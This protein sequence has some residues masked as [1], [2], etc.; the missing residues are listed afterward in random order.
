MGCRTAPSRCTRRSQPESQCSKGACIHAAVG[1]EVVGDDDFRQMTKPTKLNNCKPY[2]TSRGGIA[3]K[4][5]AHKHLGHVQYL[6]RVPSV[7]VA[8]CHWAILLV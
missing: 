4:G 3:P 8:L 6:W 1:V 2:G 7:D 5:L